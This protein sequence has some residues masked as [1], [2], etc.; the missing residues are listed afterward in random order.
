M[1]I[2]TSH[3]QENRELFYIYPELV[4]LPVETLSMTCDLS[5]LDLLVLF[6]TP[7]TSRLIPSLKQSH[8]FSASFRLAEEDNAVSNVDFRITHWD[9]TLAIVF[10]RDND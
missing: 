7:H 10:Y 1:L 9:D 4:H 8:R 2:R 5:S 3:Q 6:L